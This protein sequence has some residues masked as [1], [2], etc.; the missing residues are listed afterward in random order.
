MIN[1]VA[2]VDKAIK[3]VNPDAYVVVNGDPYIVT[4]ATGGLN[5]SEAHKFLSAIDAMLLEDETKG[6]INDAI[7]NIAPHDKLLALFDEGSDAHKQHEAMQAYK[8][9]IVPYV[10]V[11][12][13]YNKLGAFVNPGTSGHDNLN[14]GD[15][16]NRLNG[17]SGNDATHGGNGN[18]ALDGGKGADILNGGPGA[19][20][21]SGSAGADRFAYAAADD[22]L[23]SAFDTVS[24]FNAGADKF[25]L[26]FKLA[27][28]DSE[29][30]GGKL[31]EKAFVD[32][33]KSAVGKLGVHHAV[34]FAPD[35]G[36]FAGETFLIADA[37]GHVGFQAAGDLVIRLHAP[38]YLAHF[39]KADFT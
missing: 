22:S 33:L 30:V 2:A 23:A 35:K 24:G 7:Q 32:D 25:D 29:I 13:N 19:D 20:A 12:Q 11:N 9:G 34:L 10:S 36:N 37:N 27:A 17:L 39:D 28:G 38:S 14:G 16:P 31:S 15:G 21:L 3:P 8:D 6:A 1:L 4:D 18:D 26:P 5:G